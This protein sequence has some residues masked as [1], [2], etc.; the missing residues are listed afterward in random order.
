[1]SDKRVT[2]EQIEDILNKSEIN[3]MFWSPKT[4]L[5][6]AVLPNGW[7]FIEHSSCVDPDNYDHELGV[8]ICMKKITDKLWELEGY[9]LQNEVK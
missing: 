8:E 6:K 9:L 1:M 2:K 3:D 5:V 7:V 4:T